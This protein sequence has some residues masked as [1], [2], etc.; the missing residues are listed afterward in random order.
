MNDDVEDNDD[1]LRTEINAQTGRIEWASLQRFFA[2]GKTIRVA[3]DLDL[4]EVALV[5]RNDRQSELKQWIND[6]KVAPVCDQQARDWLAADAMLWAIV[7]K[8]W[9]L[10]QPI[11]AAGEKPTGNA[12]N[13]DDNNQ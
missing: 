11:A 3:P 1:P 7:V 2:A 6:D 4:V 13:A 12:S 9:V 8:P 5:I 10:V